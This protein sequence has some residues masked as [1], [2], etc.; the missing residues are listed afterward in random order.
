M[1]FHWSFRELG[2]PPTMKWETTKGRLKAEPHAISQ[3]VTEATEA[4]E[5]IA[6]INSDASRDHA[7]SSGFSRSSTSILKLALLLWVALSSTAV[8]AVSV[9]LLGSDPNVWRLSPQAQVRAA[10]I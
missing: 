7:R 2:T 9:P 8:D 3:E 10:G 1:R 6:T 4:I 5:R